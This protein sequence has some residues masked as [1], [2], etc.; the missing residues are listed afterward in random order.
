MKNL[1]V[2]ATLLLIPNLLDACLNSQSG[3]CRTLDGFGLSLGNKPPWN[4]WNRPWYDDNFGAVSPDESKEKMDR[5]E[6]LELLAFAVCEKDMEDGLT[7]KEVSSCIKFVE[8]QLPGFPMPTIE[9]FDC[10]DDDKNKTLLFP[11]WEA[12]HAS[13]MGIKPLEY[14]GYGG[15]AG[16]A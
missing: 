9:D 16:Y 3:A 8:K 2:A 6:F 10:F 7:W 14:A 12:I 5:T 13:G 4:Q 1:L 15:Y 11:E